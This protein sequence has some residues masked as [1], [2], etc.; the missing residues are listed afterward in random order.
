[1]YCVRG[2]FLKPA[3]F[4]LFKIPPKVVLVFLSL[5][6]LYYVAKL[7]E[8][9]GERRKERGAKREEKGER[10]LWEW[11]KEKDIEEIISS[12]IGM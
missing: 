10:R 12:K 8:T 3:K 5:H 11:R 9:K 2:R 6:I 7:S 1:M 4:K